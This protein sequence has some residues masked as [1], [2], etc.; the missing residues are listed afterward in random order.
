MTTDHPVERSTPYHGPT[1]DGPRVCLHNAPIDDDC[2]DCAREICKRFEEGIEEH[3]EAE[4]V[5]QALELRAYAGDDVPRVVLESFIIED[6]R[7]IRWVSVVLD[8][9]EKY[10]YQGTDGWGST[11]AIEREAAL[12]RIERRGRSKPPPDK[13]KTALPFK[14]VEFKPEPEPNNWKCQAGIPHGAGQCP[15]CPS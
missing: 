3:F 14:G 1:R 5:L 9:Y 13:I 12:G 11:Q 6:I 7:I 4:V 10:R 15:D 2:L 8:R